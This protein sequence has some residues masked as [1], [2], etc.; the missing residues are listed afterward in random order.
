MRISKIDFLR[1][2]AWP[3]VSKNSFELSYHGNKSFTL[4]NRGN[5]NLT[6]NK[7]ISNSQTSN[8]FTY[9]GDIML[10]LFYINKI[11][12]KSQGHVIYRRSKVT[13][14]IKIGVYPGFAIFHFTYL[15]HVCVKIY[16]ISISQMHM[17]ILIQ[18]CH[19]LFKRSTRCHGDHHHFIELL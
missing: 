2:T 15:E 7:W 18:F 4:F 10:P 6:N 14:L 8:T 19:D 5:V 13:A 16:C 17:C 3:K 1:V 11:F 12:T 9:C